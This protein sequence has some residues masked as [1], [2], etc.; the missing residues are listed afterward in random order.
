MD[1]LNPLGELPRAAKR[2]LVLGVRIILVDDHTLVRAGLRVLLELWGYS[3]I[4][5]GCDGEDVDALLETHRPDVLILDITMERVSGL[6]ALKRLR[7]HWPSLPVILLSMHDMPDLIV[8]AMKAGASAYL[9]KDAIDTEL[10]EAI[11]AVSNNQRYLS[12]KVSSRIVESMRVRDS[13][14]E[15]ASLTT[16]QREVL[17]LLA[18][19]MTNKEIA[20][21][22]NLSAKTVEIHRA[23]LMVRL[24][25]RTLAGLVVY[26]IR[27]GIVDVNE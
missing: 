6:E 18:S 3:V 5:E 1:Q 23:Q 14:L 11:E 15:K 19:G 4:A 9:I 8:N 10:R 25:I 13:V 16:R 12:P 21:T 7:V 17:A 24:K 26:A 20:Y 2:E 22:L 27:E